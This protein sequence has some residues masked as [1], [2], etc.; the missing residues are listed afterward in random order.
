MLLLSHTTG[1]HNVGCVDK[2]SFRKVL[3]GSSLGRPW[4]T[5]L[6]ERLSSMLRRNL[7][8]GLETAT[9][10]IRGKL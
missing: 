8:S 10:T 1:M 6:I 3:R 7:I 9:V 5:D 2:T 4:S